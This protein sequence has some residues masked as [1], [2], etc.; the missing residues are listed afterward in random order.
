M[1]YVR[2]K[3]DLSFTLGTGAFGASGEDTI[4]LTGLRVSATV[5]KAGGVSMSQLDLRVWGMTLD[6]MNKLTQLRKL[7]PTDHRRNTVT[8]TAGDDQSGMGTVFTGT[9]GQCWA[10]PKDSPDV[11][12]TAN[13]WT[14]MA[15]AI[16]PADPTSYKGAVAVDTIMAQLAAQMNPPRRLENSGVGTVLVSPYLPGTVR[17]Q[18]QAVVRAAQINVLI[19]DEVLAIW[20][21]G[22]VRGAQGIRIAPDSGLVGYPAYTDNGISLTTLYNPALIF[23]TAVTVESSLTP[24]NG[25]WAVAAVTHTLESELPGGQWFTRIECGLIGQEAPIVSG[26]G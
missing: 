15:E 19:D 13:A 12:F 9:L 22:T 4:D 18:I 20:P 21:R 25:Q 2:R 8:V 10:D 1:T 26:G 17:D 14:G 7:L 24:A 5:A 3:I 16:T 11:S 23:G 6:Q